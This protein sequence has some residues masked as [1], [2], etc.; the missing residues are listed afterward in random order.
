MM[1]SVIDKAKNSNGKDNYSQKDMLWYIV[2][3][4]D[5]LYDKQT[6][7]AEKQAENVQY[8]HKTFI[9]KRVFWQMFS[10]LLAMM[11]GLAMFVFK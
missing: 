3:R 8:M 5:E 9:G 10:M 7:Q 6:K 11:A 4:V 2:G 1:K